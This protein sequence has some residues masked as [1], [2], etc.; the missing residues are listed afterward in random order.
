MM[1]RALAIWDTSRMPP[2]LPEPCA[3][4]SP[5]QAQVLDQRLPGAQPPL[6]PH[7]PAKGSI[8]STQQCGNIPARPPPVVS[9]SLPSPPSLPTLPSFPAFPVRHVSLC[10]SVSEELACW[11]GAGGKQSVGKVPGLSE[12][13]GL[14]LARRN[15]PTVY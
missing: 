13:A 14:G 12:V 4:L 8:A 5:S 7:L 6:C 9:A 15:V 3:G 11:A 10:N 1:L 2:A